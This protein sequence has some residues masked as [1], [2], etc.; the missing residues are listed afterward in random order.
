MNEHEHLIQA[1]RHFAQCKLHITH[2]LKIMRW[3][4]EKGQ[5]V[6]LEEGCCVPSSKPPRLREVPATGP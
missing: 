4:A 6:S 1:D 5:D 3:A 2:Q